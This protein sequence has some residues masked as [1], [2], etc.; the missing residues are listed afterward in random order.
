V[1]GSDTTKCRVLRVLLIE[2]GQYTRVVLRISLL[3]AEHGFPDWVLQ[4]YPEMITIDLD[5]TW[6]LG[7][8]LDSDP[9]ALCVT[10]VFGPQVC[11][12]RIPWRAVAVVFVNWEHGEPAV[13]TPEPRRPRLE[14][15]R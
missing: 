1:A 6:P 15:V 7:L 4:E 13:E 10:L 12:C 9:E 3:G 8:D 14:V 11:R 2:G 5:P